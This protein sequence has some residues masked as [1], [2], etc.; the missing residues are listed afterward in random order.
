MATF[1]FEKQADESYLVLVRKQKWRPLGF[2]WAIKEASGRHSFRLAVDDRA[3]PRAYRSME[4]AAEAMLVIYDLVA[5]SKKRK[6]PPEKL[7]AM[8]WEA[9]PRASHPVNAQLWNSL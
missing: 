7:V 1:K 9:R 5:L 6:W 2:I 8:A 4:L 3:Q